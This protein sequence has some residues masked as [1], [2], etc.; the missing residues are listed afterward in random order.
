MNE[1]KNVALKW[2][3]CLCAVLGCITVK[4]GVI[5]DRI[6]AYNHIQV[7]DDGDMRR[8]SFNGSWETRMSLSN[9]LQGHFEYTEYFQMPWIWNTNIHRVLMAGLG[10]GS[11]QRAY[12]HYYTNVMVDTVEID[13]VVVSVAK[14]Y[15]HVVETP[16]LRIHTNDARVFLRRSTNT[17]DVILMDAYSTTRYGSSLPAHLTTKEFFTIANDH[18][19]T[20]GVLAYNVIGQI[21]G[22]R[23]SVIGAIYRTM[24]TVF[25][26]VYMFPADES[27]NVVII[28]TKSSE[29]FDRARVQ[30]DAARLLR[31]GIV[32]LPT[33]YIRTRNFDDQPPPNEAQ[34]PI[35]TDDYAPIESLLQG[36][37]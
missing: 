18:L 30:L 5:F 21:K 12:Q 24:K 27:Q 10:G 11:T 23:A 14:Q 9:P 34:S 1:I 32:T 8:L 2:A 36:T 6:S 19:T 16:M 25:P 35:L 28:G 33:F 4:A 22:Y 15:F 29:H 31:S 17:W 20:N 13:P 37:R 26:Q 3:V 7:I